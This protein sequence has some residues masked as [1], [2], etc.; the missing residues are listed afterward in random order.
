MMLIFADP[1][2]DHY[3]IFFHFP[4]ITFYICDKLLL[5]E[6]YHQMI[7]YISI[8]QLEVCAQ[9]KTFEIVPLSIKFKKLSFESNKLFLKGVIKPEQFV[10]LL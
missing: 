7:A 10:K 5:D 8:D 2:K 6:I 3:N 9:V 4:Q 1:N